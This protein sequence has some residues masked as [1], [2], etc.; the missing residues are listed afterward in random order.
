MGM[1]DASR[2][3]SHIECCQ[4]GDLPTPSSDR[5]HAPE[6]KKVAKTIRIFA[7]IG[8]FVVGFFPG[9]DL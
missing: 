3:R 1:R 4:G 5:E 7:E 6:M 8:H 2:E 9:A